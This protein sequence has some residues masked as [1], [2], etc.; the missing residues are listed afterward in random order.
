MTQPRF[1]H[2]R[3]RRF[4]RAAVSVALLACTAPGFAAPDW[5][6]IGLKLG[7]NEAEVTNTFQAYDPSGKIRML[8]ATVQ[9]SD[10]IQ[11]FNTPE[12]LSHME[13]QTTQGSGRNVLPKTFVKVWFSGP[14]GEAR[15]IA[16]LRQEHNVANAPSGEQFL[17]ALAS[18]YGQPSATDSAGTPTWEEEGKP[19][20][21]RT[22]HGISTG[23]FSSNLSH[24]SDFSDSV[25]ALERRQQGS[26]GGT[27]VDLP[28]D[29]ASC[30]AFLYY[31]GTINNPASH[32]TGAMFDVGA[33]VAAQRTR[34]AW[35]QQL[36]AEAIKKREGQAE[37]PRL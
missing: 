35:V 17:Q 33:I 6:I 31:L 8:Q 4:A 22:A 25:A 24:K 13:L 26:G 7:M 9:Y 34:N 15:A 29:L 36:E 37:A 32:F 27:G 3:S 16:I 2:L 10:K 23:P 19:S 11:S 28:A 5:D 14:P 1:V 12:F 18:K 21:I 20:C 30:G